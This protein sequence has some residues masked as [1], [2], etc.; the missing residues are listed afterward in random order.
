MEPNEYS[1][2][3]PKEEKYSTLIDFFM[4]IPDR[5]FKGVLKH[6]SETTGYS[7]GTIGVFY[8]S[9]FEK[10]EDEYF[11]TGVLVYLNEEEVIVN[12]EIFQKYISIATDI[13]LRQYVEDKAE[14]SKVLEIIKG[15]DFDNLSKQ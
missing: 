5:D 10:W 7:D 3:F 13:Y 4:F 1:S 14:V 11:E 12:N 2:F 8:S 15:I 9:S 6:I